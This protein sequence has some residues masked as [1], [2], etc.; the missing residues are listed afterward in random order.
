MA[1]T[2]LFYFLM[3]LSNDNLPEWAA[4][5]V[6]TALVLAFIGHVVYYDL[7]LKSLPVVGKYFR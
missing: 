3:T 4:L 6:N 7:P 1:I 2:A 5:A